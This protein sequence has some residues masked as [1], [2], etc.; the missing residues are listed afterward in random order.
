MKSV[1]VLS[2]GAALALT[3]AASAAPIF[4]G[5]A[6]IFPAAEPDVPAGANLVDSVTNPFASALYS[7]TVTSRVYTNDVTN[8]N[9]LNALTFVYIITSNPTSSNGIARFTVNGYAGF[10][11]DVSYRAPIT[12]VIPYFEDRQSTG[13]V[14]GWSFGNVGPGYSLIMPGMTTTWLVAQTNATDYRTVISNVIDGSVTA[15]NAFGPQIPTP[16]AAA[17]FGAGLLASSRRRR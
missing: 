7:G 2:I 15:V 3:A 12:G 6:I 10:N 1:C 5:G 17:L 9:G 16:G 11:V 8:P 4:A 13:D 14:I